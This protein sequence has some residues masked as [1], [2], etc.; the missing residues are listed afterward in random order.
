MMKTAGENIS[1]F[2]L[3][4]LTLEDFKRINPAYACDVL[5]LYQEPLI[6]CYASGAFN[7]S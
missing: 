3:R 4:W 1:V 6:D 7:Y 5:A 2:T